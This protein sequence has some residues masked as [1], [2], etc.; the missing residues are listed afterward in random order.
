VKILEIIGLQSGIANGSE[1]TF[2]DQPM[3]PASDRFSTF[4]PGRKPAAIDRGR[5]AS[6]S[7]R[8][9]RIVAFNENKI[10][11]L[12]GIFTGCLRSP[13]ENVTPSAL[14][15]NVGIRIPLDNLLNLETR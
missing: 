1:Q 3:R 14:V 2:D 8:E 7:T 11:S 15:L 10:A 4:A 5:I 9:T 13:R 12:S 6:E